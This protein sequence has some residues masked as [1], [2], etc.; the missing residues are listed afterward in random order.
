MIFFQTRIFI[1]LQISVN[2]HIIENMYRLL[3]LAFSI[4]S[5]FVLFDGCTK[6]IPLHVNFFSDDKS[7]SKTNL[8]DSS[9]LIPNAIGPGLVLSVDDQNGPESWF[10]I[11]QFLLDS[12]VRL[13]FYVHHFDILDNTN[14]NILKQLQA[15]GHE[16]G[17]HTRTHPVLGQYVTSYGLKT[18][19]KNEIT[20]IMDTMH[21]LGYNPVNFA[22]PY[23]AWT[24]KSDSALLNYFFS[25]RKLD[26]LDNIKTTADR[27][28]FYVNKRYQ[29]IYTA[30]CIDNPDSSDINQIF[31]LMDYAKSSKQTLCLFTHTLS[32]TPIATGY[33]IKDTDAK[34]I[35][36]Y[37]KKIGLTFY[38]AKDIS[39]T[40]LNQ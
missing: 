1:I 33:F 32:K 4:F 16:I 26:Y 37:A 25:I 21:L 5:A 10:N 30:C 17:H 38:T 2:T 20:S 18:Y 31:S 19:V 11:R 15:D 39:R 35:I 13:T 12:G 40:S 14:M 9:I 24:Y 28:K 6:D 22:Y 29:R 34:R 23:G 27:N 7:T 3:V 36:S 8:I